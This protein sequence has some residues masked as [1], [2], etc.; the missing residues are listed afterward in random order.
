MKIRII[1]YSLIFFIGAYIF[2]NIFIFSKY[3][4]SPFHESNKYFWLFTDAAQKE[5]NPIISG[6]WRR[7]ND[8]LYHY[9]YKKNKFSIHI[10]EFENIKNANIE[11]VSINEGKDLSEIEFKK[12]ETLDSDDWPKFKTKLG[13]SLDSNINISLDEFSKITTTFF[14]EKYKGFCGNINKLSISDQKGEHKV[15]IEYPFEQG[16]VLFLLYKKAESLF[17]IIVDS[18]QK[19]VVDQRILEIFNFS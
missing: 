8:V 18:N 15:V 4:Y 1:V 13:F 3:G 9:L 14:S 6:G 12:Y 5:I 16:A 11:S 7:D 2:Y 17:L 10:W 19:E